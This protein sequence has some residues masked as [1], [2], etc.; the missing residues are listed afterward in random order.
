MPAK[1]TPGSNVQ[2]ACVRTIE[3]VGILLEF[4]GQQAKSWL[5]ADFEDTRRNLAPTVRQLAVPPCRTCS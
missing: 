3:D 2:A 5:Q 4:L 1:T